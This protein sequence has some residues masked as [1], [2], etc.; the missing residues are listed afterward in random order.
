MQNMQKTFTKEDLLTLDIRR[1]IYQFI[2]KNPGLH[3]RELVRRLNIP[4][5][6]LEYHLKYLEKKEFLIIKRDSKYNNYFISKDIDKREKNILQ[7]IRIETT[8]NV[9]L[10]VFFMVVASQIELSKEL[11]KH[12][13][14]I[15]FHLKRLLKHGI[16]ET[17]EIEN[18]VINTTS[19]NAQIVKREKSKNEIFYM[20]KEAK[21][22]DKLLTI[23]YKN[24]Y[25]YDI[26]S[27]A[28]FSYPEDAI[29]S[30]THTKK[31]TTKETIEELE[32]VFYDIFP[33]PYHT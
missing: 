3:F 6:T 26:I 21:E 25:Y 32:K 2:L 31:R 17:V 23:F 30:S 5:S 33:H 27:E 7:I 4:R 11:D 28:I 18:G 14:T 20:I 8:R 29:K 19:I 16:I 22:I 12:P 1:I 24:R 10:Y 9:L 13:T 15:N